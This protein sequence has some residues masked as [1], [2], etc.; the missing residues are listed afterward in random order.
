MME[1]F[2]DALLNNVV[3]HSYVSRRPGRLN[4]CD[5]YLRLTTLIV[6]RMNFGGFICTRQCHCHSST[7]I[8]F[9]WQKILILSSE[10]VHRHYLEF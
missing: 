6:F 10:D 8:I 4:V 3:L 2:Y 5:I 1:E 9:C 7:D